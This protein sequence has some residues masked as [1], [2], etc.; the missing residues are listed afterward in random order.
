MRSHLFGVSKDS[1]PSLLDWWD[2]GKAHMKSLSINYCRS[3]SAKKKVRFK[4]LFEKVA[5]LKLLVDQ[6]NVSALSDYKD[7][8]SDLQEFS[9]DQARGA[10]VCSRAR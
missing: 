10:Q 4:L 6:G 1:F 7:A 9:L 5:N 2:L 3:C 8:L